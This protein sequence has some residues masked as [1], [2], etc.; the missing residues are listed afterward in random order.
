MAGP[1]KDPALKRK[2]SRKKKPSR[3]EVSSSSESESDILSPKTTRNKHSNIPNGVANED[4]A[5]TGAG[6]STHGQNTRVVAN[7]TTESKPQR[8]AED[9]RS[10]YLR[11]ITAEVADDLDQVRKANDFTIRSVPMLVHALK[12][13]LSCFSAEERARVVDAANA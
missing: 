1:E 7:A 9:F 3:T 8:A 10:I 6:T 11:K 5:T 12:Q 2:K 13:G 4:V